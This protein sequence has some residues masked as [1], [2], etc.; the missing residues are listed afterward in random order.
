MEARAD[1]GERQDGGAVEL[2]RGYLHLPDDI[3]AGQGGASYLGTIRVL[4]PWA[5][6]VTRVPAGSLLA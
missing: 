6:A 3:G 1:G 4:R 2:E 5:D